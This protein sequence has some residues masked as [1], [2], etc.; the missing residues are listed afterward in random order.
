M[1]SKSCT[2]AIRSVLFLGKNSTESKKLSVD[3]ISEKIDLPREFLA[4]IL[5]QL[6]KHKLVE[7]TKG[8]NGGFYLSEKNMNSSL[9]EVI[10]CFDGPDILSTCILGLEDCS[11]KRPCPYHNDFKQLRNNLKKTL[12]E[13]TILQAIERIEKNNLKL[14]DYI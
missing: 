13:E 7:S 1:F 12:A 10:K 11:D 8:R 6:T 14:K 5:Q 4:K 3:Y 9:L 2:Y